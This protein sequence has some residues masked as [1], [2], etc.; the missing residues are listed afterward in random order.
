MELYALKVFMTVATERS[1]SRA[2][3]LLGRSQSAITQAMQKLEREFGEQLLDRTARELTLTDSGRLVLGFG[4]RFENLERE[5]W[6][7]YA[8]LR[9]VAA[10]RLVIG[11]NETT[12]FYLMPHLVGYRER[13][14]KVKVQV[15]RSRSARIPMEVID[16]DLEFGVIPYAP[17]DSRLESFVLCEDRMALVVSPRHPLAQQ[18][19]VSIHDLGGDSF[20]VHNV[21]SPYHDVVVAAFQRAKVPLN[22]D[23]EMPTVES[24]RTMV[25]ENKGIA[26]LPHQCVAQAIEQGLL[27]ELRVKELDL[28][29]EVRLVYPS[30]R[31]LSHAAK[32]FLYMVMG[33]NGSAV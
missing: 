23:V 31:V 28:K 11:S 10:G 3:E 2:G 9:D 29:R 18:E 32:A 19:V 20:I 30:C 8:E 16:G 21:L 24:I 27:R 26:F 1:F 14:P 12:S 13:Y 15:R 17:D 33:T 7:A 4:R 22:M 6:D 25:S 5:L